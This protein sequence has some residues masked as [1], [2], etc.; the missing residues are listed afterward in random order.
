MEDIASYDYLM[1]YILRKKYFI[2]GSVKNLKQWMVLKLIYA[3]F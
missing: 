1:V 2:G 3:T